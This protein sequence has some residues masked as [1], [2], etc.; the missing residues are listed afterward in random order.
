MLTAAVAC[1]SRL[2]AAHPARH[3]LADK[4]VALVFGPEQ[5]LGL[6]AL[7]AAHAPPSGAMPAAVLAAVLEQCFAVD[8]ACERACVGAATGRA[9]SFLG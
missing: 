8:P 5:V 9:G 2:P 1:A 3:L 4:H 6:H 7:F